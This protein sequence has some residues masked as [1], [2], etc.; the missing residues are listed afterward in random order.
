MI[1]VNDGSTD[2]SPDYLHDVA[3]ADPRIRVVEQ[4]NQGQQAAANRGV[5]LARAPLIA[6]MDADDVSDPERFAKQLAYMEEHHEVGLLGGQIRRIGSKRVGLESNFPREHDAIMQWLRNNHHAICNP[7]T[8]FRKHL[9]EEIDG[10]WDYNIAEDWDM[11]LRIGERSKLANLSDVVLA[12]RFHTGS[13]NGRRII[14]AQLF[15]EYAAHLSILRARNRPEIAFEEF[16][17]QHRSS[18][19]PTSW[20]FYSD[21]QS[22]AQYRE[23]IAEIYDGRAV[24]GCARLGLSMLMSPRRALRRLSNMMARTMTARTG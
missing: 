10:Y 5:A 2:R 23:A 21:S 12:Y 7:T 20:M 6:R 18:R 24:V 11:F 4:D 1:V 3:Q 9:F 17:T 14:E 13:I 15:N 16:L 22:I 8:V 19:W